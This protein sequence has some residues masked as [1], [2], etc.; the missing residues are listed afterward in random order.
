MT[1]MTMMLNLLNK[2]VMYGSYETPH[3]CICDCVQMSYLD[4][5]PPSALYLIA[6]YSN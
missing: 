6:N 1:M 4:C 2:Q 3:Q 5:L